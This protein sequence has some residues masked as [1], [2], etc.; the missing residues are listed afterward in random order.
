MPRDVLSMEGL[1]GILNTRGRA[2]ATLGWVLLVDLH[3]LGQL[4]PRMTAT[5]IHRV[6]RWWKTRISKR[7]N[8]N[9]YPLVFVPL[10]GVEHGGSADR[11]EPEPE[12][13][14]LISGAHVLRRVA[15][16]FVRRQEASQRC[17]HTSRAA[18]AG[19]AVAHTNALRLALNFNA[20]LTTA[21]GSGSCIH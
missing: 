4:N 2:N 14:S 3:S 11:A 6:L 13:G 21:A 7:A 16:D 5:V 19:Q 17:E 10:L 12:L 9:R 1:G 8:R 20:Q 15:G 18:L